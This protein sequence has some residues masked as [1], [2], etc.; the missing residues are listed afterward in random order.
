[1]NEFKLSIN[2]FLNAVCCSDSKKHAPFAH[3]QKGCDL[4]SALDVM[5]NQSFLEQLKFSISDKSLH[6]YLYNWM[7]PNMSPDKVLRPHLLVRLC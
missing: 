7:C 6:F 5:E 3:S 2:I 1:M 4:F